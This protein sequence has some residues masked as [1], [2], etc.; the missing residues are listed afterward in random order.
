MLFQSRIKFNNNIQY[1]HLQTYLREELPDRNINLEGY[2]QNVTDIQRHRNDINILT[3]AINNAKESIYAAKNDGE[4]VFANRA[5]RQNHQVPDNVCIE[6]LKIYDLLNDISNI[7]ECENRYSQVEPGKFAE[8]VTYNPF[9]H[10]PNILA[11]EGTLYHV[12]K[13][14]GES[15]YWSFA[16]DITERLKYESQIKQLNR[17]MDTVIDNLP[18]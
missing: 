18:L 2:V 8:Y 3:H 11:F 7:E 14:D 4:M 10:N 17:S 9:E 16:H 15:T 6:E 1:L 12:T 13:D 5:F